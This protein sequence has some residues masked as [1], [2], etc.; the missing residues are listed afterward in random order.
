MSEHW[1]FPYQCTYYVQFEELT[2]R[3]RTFNEKSFITFNAMTA[4]VRLLGLYASIPFWRSLGL[5]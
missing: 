3:K 2:K 1:F 4:L 5:L